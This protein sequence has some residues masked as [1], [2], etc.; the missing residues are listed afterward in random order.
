M[1]KEE[2]K[3]GIHDLLKDLNQNVV[4]AY[5]KEGMAFGNERYSSWR[6]K[7][8][9]FLDQFLPN[10]KIRF[11]RKQ[12]FL[13]GIQHSFKTPVQSFCAQDGDY[14]QVHSYL[15]SLALDI[16]QDNYD[17]PNPLKKSNIDE[18]VK[19]MSSGL[20][21]VIGICNNFEKVVRQLKSPHDKRATIHI[22]IIN[23]YDVQELFYA[24]LHLY[25]ADIRREECTQSYAGKSARVDFLLK[26]ENII[27]EI[28]KT[29]KSL[30]TK[31]VCDQLLIDIG[32]YKVHLGC[33]T[34]VCFVYDPERYIGNTVAL[35]DD[36]SGLHDGVDV[37]VVITPSDS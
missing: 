8:T 13:G 11:N 16:E 14:E 37:H 25:F 15:S 1:N 33:K 21:Q 18:S 29:S 31:E 5:K 35:K 32:R 24:L 30:T 36:L 9:K 27:I 26:R 34:L 28:K 23:E 17:P 12:S 22:D 4:I 3:Q 20:E 7:V 2:I 10:E 6:K 19:S